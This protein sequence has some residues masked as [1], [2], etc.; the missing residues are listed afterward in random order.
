MT[1]YD[2]LQVVNAVQWIRVEDTDSGEITLFPYG[3]YAISMEKLQ[4]IVESFE[5]FTVKE[6]VKQSSGIAIKYFLLS[7]YGGKSDG[8]N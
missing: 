2:V 8:S 3:K 7:N 5:F 4:G 1:V 6:G